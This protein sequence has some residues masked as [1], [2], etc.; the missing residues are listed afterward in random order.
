MS[1][2]RV[3]RSGAHKRERGGVAGVHA[4]QLADCRATDDPRLKEK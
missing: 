1:N 4:R 3:D 2:Q